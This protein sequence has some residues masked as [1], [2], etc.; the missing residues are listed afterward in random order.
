MTDEEMLIKIH[1]YARVFG[2]PDLREI[3]DRFSELVEKEKAKERTAELIQ[4]YK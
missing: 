1:D 3:A 4:Q 2:R